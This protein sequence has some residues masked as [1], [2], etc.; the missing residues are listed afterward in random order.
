MKASFSFFPGRILLAFSILESMHNITNSRK[1]I[2]HAGGHC[3]GGGSSSGC[4]DFNSVV[5]C[6]AR[7]W[8]SPEEP[9]SSSRKPRPR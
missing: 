1:A 9:R 6:R 3:R 7:A 4:G 8:F 5:Q 2:R